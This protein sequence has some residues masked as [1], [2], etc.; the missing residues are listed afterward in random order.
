MNCEQNLREGGTCP[1]PA[2]YRYTWPGL[3]E[4]VI[5][6]EHSVHMREAARAMGMLLQLIP[7]EHGTVKE[8]VLEEASKDG[9]R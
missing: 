4:A 8:I 1:A 2:A 9:G 6:E 7:L 3:D 5:C